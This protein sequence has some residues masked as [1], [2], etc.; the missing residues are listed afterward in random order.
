[1]R[2]SAP[3]SESPSAFS[4]PPSSHASNHNRDIGPSPVV[5]DDHRLAPSPPTS[6]PNLCFN[7]LATTAPHQAAAAL[8]TTASWQATSC[9]RSPSSRRAPL[10]CG[11]ARIASII[12]ADVTWWTFAGAAAHQAARHRGHSHENGDS[13]TAVTVCGPLRVSWCC[14]GPKCPCFGV[15]LASTFRRR[16]VWHVTGVGEQAGIEERR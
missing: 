5:D 16:R 1:M 15:S 14:H 8:R 13:G 7:Q 2:D 9:R 10:I 4:R 6:Q 3:A 12:A 11:I